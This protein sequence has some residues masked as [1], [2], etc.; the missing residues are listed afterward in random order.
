LGFQAGLPPDPF[1]AYLRSTKERPWVRKQKETADEAARR[2]RSALLTWNGD[3]GRIADVDVVA[4]IGVMVQRLRAEEG[5]V[6]LFREFEAFFRDGIERS[7]VEASWAVA[8]EV[9]EQSLLAGE[10]RVHLHA[11]FRVR[12]PQ[13]SFRISTTAAEFRFRGQAPHWANA[14]PS[15]RRA[16]NE[17]QALFYCQVEKRSSLFRAGNC[18]PHR[19]YHVQAEWAFALLE[20]NKISEEVARRV[21]V[22]GC[23]NVPGVLRNLESVITS[24]REQG[25]HTMLEEARL[26]LA[27]ETRPAVAVSAVL[28]WHALFEQHRH[29]YPFLVLDGPTRLGKTL[30]AQQQVPPGTALVVD[31]SG[32]VEPALHSFDPTTHKGVVFDEASA[33]LVLRKRRL[34]QAPPERVAL[35]GSATNCH[36]YHVVVYRQRLIVC[37]N[38]WKRDVEELA[39]EDRAWLEGNCIYVHVDRPMWV[40]AADAAPA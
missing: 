40:P 10:V 7:G 1:L 16:R 12:A 17:H 35:G 18:E 33:S 5:V 37:T 8:A 34:F 23:K 22:G 36:L 6:R 13:A 39:P 9:C 2:C 20:G 25:C 28:A 3:F 26:A 19:D 30:Y 31:C 29:R 14:A 21:V 38:R 11:S 27:A 4:D 24:R 15:Q 32:A